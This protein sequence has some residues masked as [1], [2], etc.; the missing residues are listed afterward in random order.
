MLACGI[1]A[2]GWV[3]RQKKK[4]YEGEEEGRE[5]DRDSVRD[6]DSYYATYVIGKGTVPCVF[7]TDLP[8]SKPY[9]IL[10]NCLYGEVYAVNF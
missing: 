1:C 10:L 4:S 5:R 7:Y 2:P 8:L 6:R 3:S 9:I